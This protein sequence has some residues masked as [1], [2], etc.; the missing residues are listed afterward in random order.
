MLPHA[1]AEGTP[2]SK[3]P[4][5]IANAVRLGRHDEAEELRFELVR[6]KIKALVD[7]APPLKPAQIELLR[8]LFGPGTSQSREVA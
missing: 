4:V 8:S 6:A 1:G 5:R 7:A 2:P 3:M